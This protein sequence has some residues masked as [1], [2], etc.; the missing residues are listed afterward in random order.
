M[1]KQEDLSNSMDRYRA[2]ANWEEDIKDIRV[3]QCDKEEDP[4]GYRV[5]YFRMIDEL[6]DDSTNSYSI[7]ASYL[8]NRLRK[9]RKAGFIAPMTQ[10]AIELIDKKRII[11]VA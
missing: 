11:K 9:L 10:R 7:G 2:V 5:I 8:K 3:E 4:L 1:F 6:K